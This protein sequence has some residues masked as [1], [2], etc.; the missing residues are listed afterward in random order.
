[1][2]VTSCCAVQ[3][4]GSC[5]PGQKVRLALG[6]QPSAEGLE[7]QGRACLVLL[8]LEMAQSLLCSS[9]LANLLGQ[10]GFLGQ[11]S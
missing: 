3:L 2:H 9:Q 10:M 4:L 7:H 8:C 1:M 5:H 11:A 6:Q